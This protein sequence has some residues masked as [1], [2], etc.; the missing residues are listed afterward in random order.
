[1]TYNN[2][3]KIGIDKNQFA[4]M[5]IHLGFI[6]NNKLNDKYRL[7]FALGLPM[8]TLLWGILIKIQKKLSIAKTPTTAKKSDIFVLMSAILG[9]NVP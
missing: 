3:T 8:V 2:F 9:Y 7:E 1:M 6:S 4:T 5:M